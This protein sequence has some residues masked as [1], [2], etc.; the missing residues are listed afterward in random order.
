MRIHIRAATTIVFAAVAVS[1]CG[2]SSEGLSVI[3]TPVPAGPA[4]E[5]QQTETTQ[6]TEPPQPTHGPW[7]L[8]INWDDV[9]ANTVTVPL[10]S[11]ETSEL[12][13]FTPI[14]PDLGILPTR[15]AATDPKAGVGLESQN[16]V[17]YYDLE[18]G[19][20]IG[21]GRVVVIEAATSQTDADIRKI[22][23]SRNDPEGYTVVD[24]S[25]RSVLLISGQGLGRARFVSGGQVFDVAG[26]QLT[27]D[28]ALAVA[29][30]LIAAAS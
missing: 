6:P 16:A 3:T 28:G 12:L 5:T 20:D 4:E 1:A 25:G 24:V 18:A 9:V 29:G 15:V 2:S 10:D 14:V 8:E 13:G 7:R 22:A 23:E 19:S 21:E 17:F 26:P 27:P 11:L 30:P